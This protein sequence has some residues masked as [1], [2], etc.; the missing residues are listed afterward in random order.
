MKACPFCRGRATKLV[1]LS[2]GLTT[3][4]QCG[5]SYGSLCLISVRCL[6]AGCFYPLG[7]NRCVFCKKPRPV[8]PRGRSPLEALRS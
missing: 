4:Q 6:M 1:S 8:A 2:T 7:D 3:C 5:R